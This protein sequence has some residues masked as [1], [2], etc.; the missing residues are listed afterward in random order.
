MKLHLKKLG[1]ALAGVAQ[2][3][4]SSSCNQKVAGSIPGSGTYNPMSGHIWE[5]INQPIDASLLHWCFSLPS[6]F[7]KTKKKEK[8]KEKENV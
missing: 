3:V 8:R 6:S 2:L 7:S 1:E 5:A 4:G